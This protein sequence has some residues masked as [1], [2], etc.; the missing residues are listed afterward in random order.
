[1]LHRAEW[2]LHREIFILLTQKCYCEVGIFIAIDYLH[3]LAVSSIQH[4]KSYREELV[5]YIF[6]LHKTA[7]MIV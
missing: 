1:M 7:G 3:R 5:V 6:S 2:T 4:L